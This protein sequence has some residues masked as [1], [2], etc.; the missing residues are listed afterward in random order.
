MRR[1]LWITPPV[2]AAFAMFTGLSMLIASGATLPWDEAVLHWVDAIRGT[3][4]TDAMLVA[5]YFGD[6]KVEVPFALG[7][8]ALLWARSAPRSAVALL[9][10]GVT[11]E[12]VYLLAKL[13]FHRPRPDL[14][15]R[16]SGA[17]WYSYPSGHAMLAPI[18]WSL[19]LVLLA[20]TMPAG[21]RW[22]FLL[23]AVVLPVAIAMSR[24]Y[25][26]VHYPSDV[27]GAL[28]LGVG[29]MLLWLDWSSASSTSRSASTM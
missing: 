8:C 29:W 11:G 6:G 27:L 9:L 3:V 1:R 18:L 17:G 20:R 15:E 21:R 25:L 13:A 23:P 12:L 5:T 14:I 2:F 4:L 10:G 24:V 28:A 26:G 16:L 7:A 22:P 19:A